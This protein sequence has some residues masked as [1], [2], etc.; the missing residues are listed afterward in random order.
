[1]KGSVFLGYGLSA[2]RDRE[3]E[4]ALRETA[5]WQH[6]GKRELG[7]VCVSESQ[8]ASCHHR[9]HISRSE[10]PPNWH[11]FV[12]NLLILK[13]VGFKTGLCS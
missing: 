1:M 11:Y 3:R 12:C 13:G 10:L 2:V 9:D 4:A 7:A 6:L 5:I 8:L